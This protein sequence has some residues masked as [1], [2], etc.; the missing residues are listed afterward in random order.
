MNGYTFAAKKVNF[1]GQ[2]GYIVTQYR[3]GEKRCEQFVTEDN[4]DEFCRAIGTT[5]MLIEQ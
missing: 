5:P 2:P 4:F 1:D 3:D